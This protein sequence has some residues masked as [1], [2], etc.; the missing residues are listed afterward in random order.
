M[1][2]WKIRFYSAGSNS[3]HCVWTLNGKKI[4]FK[5]SQVVPKKYDKNGL[6]IHYVTEL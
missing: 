3:M 2:V 1:A 6:Y 5:F 4:I